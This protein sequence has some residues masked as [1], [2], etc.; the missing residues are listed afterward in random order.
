M[1]QLA[2]WNIVT[3]KLSASYFRYF[4]HLNNYIIYMDWSRRRQLMASR[5]LMQS[6][7]IGVV[8]TYIRLHSAAR[9]I[10]IGIEHTT[11]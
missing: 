10:S 6:Q 4:N 3:V 7:I 5:Q 2:E 8:R 11:Y 9:L 1:T